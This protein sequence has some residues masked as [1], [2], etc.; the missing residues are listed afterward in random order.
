M[1]EKEFGQNVEWKS[2]FDTEQQNKQFKELLTRAEDGIENLSPQDRELLIKFG[3]YFLV[4][5]KDG[6]QACEAFQAAQDFKGLRRTAEYLSREYAD[7]FDLVKILLFLEDHEG[8]RNLLNRKDV[9]FNAYI[10]GQVF[11][12]FFDPLL[13]HIKKNL[14]ENETPVATGGVNGG[15]DFVAIRNLAQKYDIAVPIA[16]G[17]LNQGAISDLFGMPTRI[18]DVEAHNRKKPKGKWMNSVSPEDFDGKNVL[19][20]DKDAVTGASI[21]KT[22]DMLKPF[23]PESVGVYFMHPVLTDKTSKFGTKIDGLPTDLEIFSPSNAP[24]NDAGDVYMEAHERLETL[25]GRRRKMERLF[26]EEA[27]KIQEQFPILAEAMRLFASKQSST[28]DLL[29]PQMA[30]VLEM[31]KK[32]LSSM[33]DLYKSHCEYLKSGLYGREEN[34]ENF[35]RLLSTATSLPFDFE[36]DLIR[37]RYSG[38]GE[39][40][41]AKR[42]VDNLHIPGYPSA[43]FNAAQ[44][45]VRDGCDIALIVG[46]E[47]FAY[48]PYFKDFGVRTIAVNIPE[49]GV[50]EQRTIK[51]FDDLSILRG[52]KVLVVEDDVQ[53]GATLKKLLEHLKKHDTAQLSLYLGLTEAFQ[54][55]ENIPSQFEKIYTAQE[56]HTTDGQFVTYLESRGLK[57]FKV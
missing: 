40:M 49:S 46:P 25:Y 53:T 13:E 10:Q 35:T 33:E 3:N 12:Q 34:V 7:S 11:E 52:K 56:D 37:A 2:G 30:G 16:R 20:L 31:R 28:F 32:I 26:M 42:G 5:K 22:M 45:A 39:K 50:D 6:Y 54:K 38:Q 47:G 23:K 21:N 36:S 8:I 41:A 24:L 19:L 57:L 4:V 48:E 43:A 18:A 1:S 55:K 17:G 15:T 9:K 14:D 27:K 51:I 29:N 44:K